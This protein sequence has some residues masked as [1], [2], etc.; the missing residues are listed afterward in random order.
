[1]I[2]F[3]LI[4]LGIFILDVVA[5]LDFEYRDKVPIWLVIIGVMCSLLPVVNF[6]IGIVWGIFLMADW[7]NDLKGSNIVTKFLKLLNKKI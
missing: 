4:S 2:V 1:M 6:A 3:Y 7:N 5:Y